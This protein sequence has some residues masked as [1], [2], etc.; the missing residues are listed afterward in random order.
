MRSVIRAG[1]DGLEE[2]FGP[3]VL[4]FSLTAES[5][6]IVWRL[7]GARFLFLPLPTALFAG[8]GAT[9]TIADD[10]R[11]WFDARAGMLGIGLLV[12]YKGWLAEPAG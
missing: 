10:G 1:R 3:I 2:S 5:D 8:C 11:Y 9:E 4:E 6:A 12:Q 7:K